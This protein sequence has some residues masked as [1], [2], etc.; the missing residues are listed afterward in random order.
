MHD[1]NENLKCVA[2][3]SPKGMTLGSEWPEKDAKKG[4]IAGPFY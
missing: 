2:D 1:F 4:C 3:P